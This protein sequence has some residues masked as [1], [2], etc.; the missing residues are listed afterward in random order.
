MKTLKSVII[1]LML[2]TFAFIP[3]LTEAAKILSK[4]EWSRA[5]KLF[6]TECSMCHQKNGKGV[7][8]IY[9]PLKNADYIKKE[10]TVDLLRGIIYGRSGT[11]VV[12]GEQYNGVMITEVKEGT[13]DHDIALLMTYVYQKFNGISK[14]VTIE[15]VKKARKMGK[16]PVH[17]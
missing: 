10:S 2:L 11:I 6:G 12:N 14:F 17:K 15:E 4:K 1:C 7:K 13:T 5:K 3:L 16:L 8:R 9:P